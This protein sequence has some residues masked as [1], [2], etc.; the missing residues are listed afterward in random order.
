MTTPITIDVFCDSADLTIMHGIVEQ[1]P[2]VRGWT[3]NPSI[4]RRCGVVDYKQFIRDALTKLP[5]LPLSVEVV[6]DDPRE[7]DRQARCLAQMARHHGRHD[8]L[9]VKVPAVNSQGISLA[10]LMRELAH[11]GLQI[12]A[13]AV[14][15]YES[16]EAVTDALADGPPSWVSVFVGRLA[17]RGTEPLDEMPRYVRRIN[18]STRTI[19]ASPREP[20][21]VLQAQRLGF[22]AITVF[23]DFIK[24]LHLLGKDLREFEIE[25]SRMFLQDSISAGY[26]L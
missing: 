22:D 16:A 20:L 11:D 23:H 1:Y 9:Y 25:T 21:N 7:I 4:C 18:Q 26:E 13:T 8:T 15:S 3:T 14:L 12:N 10:P 17:D 5:P 24:K 19:W 6:A 2:Y